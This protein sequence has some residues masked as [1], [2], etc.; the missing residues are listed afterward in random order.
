MPTV[1]T[2]QNHPAARFDESV[3]TLDKRARLV[4]FALAATMVARVW[5][6]GGRAWSIEVATAFRNAE[7]TSQIAIQSRLELADQIAGGAGRPANRSRLTQTS[8]SSPLPSPR[9]PRARAFL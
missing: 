3:A 4:V 6:L 1:N 7:E 5:D 8:S 9:S 2:D